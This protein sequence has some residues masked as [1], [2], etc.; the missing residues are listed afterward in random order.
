MPIDATPY[1]IRATSMTDPPHTPE[2]SRAVT[3]FELCHDD[4]APSQRDVLSAYCR[5]FARRGLFI[6]PDPNPEAGP[7]LFS[8]GSPIVDKRP[9]CYWSWDDNADVDAEADGCAWVWHSGPRRELLTGLDPRVI[10][11]PRSDLFDIRGIQSTPES[12]ADYRARIDVAWSEKRDEIYFRGH[13]T[14][15]QTAANA[16]ARACRLVQDVGLP[17]NVGILAETT[18][19][20]VAA[21]VPVKDPDPLHVMAR[22]KFVLSL[23]GNHAFNPRLYRGLEGGSLVFHQATPT[24]QLLED[25]L[26]E[27]GHH[28][29]E[30]APDLSDLVDKLDYFLRHPVEARTIAEAGHQAWM[31]S[32]FVSAPYT[33][34]DV[35]WE[36]FTSQPNWHDFRGTFDVR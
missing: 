19:P 21:H 5:A 20:D 12:W 14:G 9:H 8:N 27:P 32:L 23:W 4:L 28:Y 26:L 1:S 10:L 18:P 13:F 16:R 30:V 33:V 29:V 17:A 3:V 2:G 36:R 15:D 31:E 24:I 25:G 6:K 34:S 11:L 22:Y 35:I 7:H